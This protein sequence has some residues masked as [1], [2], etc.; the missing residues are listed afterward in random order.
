MDS[1]GYISNVRV[2]LSP[3]SNDITISMLSLGRRRLV[4]TLSLPIHFG[5]INTVIPQLE[6]FRASLSWK[7][8]KGQIILQLVW[9]SRNTLIKD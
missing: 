6:R 7:V 1:D 2:E 3:F 8:S 5:N 9:F 4:Y